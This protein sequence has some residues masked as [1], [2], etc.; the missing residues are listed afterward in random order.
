MLCTLALAA[1]CADPADE[2][3]EAPAASC[4]AAIEAMTVCY[5]DLAA[6]ARCS[7]GSVAEFDRVAPN[8]GDCDGVDD[9]GKADVF[10]V[11]GCGA[12][13]HVCGWIFCCDDYGLTWLPERESDWDFVGA[14]QAFQAAAPVDSMQQ[15][16]SSSRS[17]L[18]GGVSVAFLQDVVEV[19]GKGAVQMAVE[20]TQALAEVPYDEFNKVLAADRWGVELDHYLGGE[21]KVYD[22]DSQGRV[23]RQLERMVL[24]PFPCDWES[25]L[26][27][28]D[29]TK[30]EV[31]DHRDDGATVYWR[32]M[33]SDNGSTETDVGS[34]EFRSYDA[35]S[36][37]ITF[38][39]AHRLN[40]P[41]RIHIPNSIVK[42][43]LGQTFLDFARRY[44]RIV[45]P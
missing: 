24:S 3:V 20:V 30:V 6:Q 5:P 23:V 4:E 8:T 27:N 35:T 43:A 12:G 19:E 40:A 25:A 14:V 38:H 22:R 17:D 33:H 2:G 39:S 31:I 29:M 34:V 11:G 28:N 37:L 10:A 42:L 16:T 18:V 45:R 13:E 1:A 41:G 21:V 7:D 32:V 26:S 44:T 9:M 36:T 15:L